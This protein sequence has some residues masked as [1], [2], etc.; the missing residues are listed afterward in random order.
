MG[1]IKGQFDTK[2]KVL[3]IYISCY[4]DKYMTVFEVKNRKTV[5]LIIFFCTFAVGF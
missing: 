2:S 4:I 3:R 1:C 5:F